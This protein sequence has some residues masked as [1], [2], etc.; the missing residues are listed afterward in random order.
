[1]LELGALDIRTQSLVPYAQYISSLGQRADRKRS[2]RHPEL[3]KVSS[4]VVT[5][6][7]LR[8]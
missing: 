2:N 8:G 1:M 7:S 5:D 6:R 4:S 3:V